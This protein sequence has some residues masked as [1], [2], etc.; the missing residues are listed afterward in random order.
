MKDGVHFQKMY[1]TQIQNAP[2]GAD[3]SIS[4][5]IPKKPDT[6]KGIWFFFLISLLIVNILVPI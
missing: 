3:S 2:R 6:H 1:P 5:S 4:E